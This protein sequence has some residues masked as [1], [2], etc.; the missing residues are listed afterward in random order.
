MAGYPTL[1]CSFLIC[2]ALCGQAPPMRG[3][4]LD[5]ARAPVRDARITAVRGGR[6]AAAV[7]D[8]AGEFSLALDPGSYT[9][10][11]SA[12]GFRDASE[13]VEVSSVASAPREFV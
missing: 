9:L 6:T 2:G 10:T 4:V 3:R 11:V 5:P 12:T 1:I 7:S 13:M 8:A